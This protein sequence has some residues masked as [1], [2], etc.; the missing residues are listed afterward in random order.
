MS[1]ELIKCNTSKGAVGDWCRLGLAICSPGC[2]K[3]A[4]WASYGE[5]KPV[6][7]TPPRPLHQ[8]PP[9]GSCPVW[10]PVLISFSDRLWCGNDI[11]HFLC[12]VLM[13]MLLYRNN[14]I[15]NWEESSAPTGSWGRHNRGH[16]TAPTLPGHGPAC[17]G[18]EY[19]GN[20]EG[21]GQKS[22][23]QCDSLKPLFLTTRSKQVCPI[24]F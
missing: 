3:E 22:R 11:S 6:S 7:S 20:L 19:K 8:L 2:C 4:G 16:C 23:G 18:S 13:I 24:P 5:S 15:T 14:R 12:K 10:V 17:E 1:K 9:P 21:Q